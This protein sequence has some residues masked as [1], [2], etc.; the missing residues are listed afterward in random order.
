MSEKTFTRICA[1]FQYFVGVLNNSKIEHE[2]M[3]YVNAESI[4]NV[5]RT[6]TR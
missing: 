5:V 4:K 1:Y 6:G 3:A 2:T